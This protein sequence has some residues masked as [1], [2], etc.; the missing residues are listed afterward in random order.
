MSVG[1]DFPLTTEELISLNIKSYWC[2]FNVTVKLP[3]SLVR[4]LSHVAAERPNSWFSNLLSFPCVHYHVFLNVDVIFKC[5]CQCCCHSIYWIIYFPF[6][7][8]AIEIEEQ[9]VFCLLKETNKWNGAV[10]FFSS[11]AKSFKGSSSCLQTHKKYY[12]L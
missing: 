3:T 2:T 6:R 10:R 9:C 4:M 11:S 5:L 1:L 12:W 7:I 8:N